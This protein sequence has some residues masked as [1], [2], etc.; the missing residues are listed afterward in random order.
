[1]TTER[2]TDESWAW[3]APR[4][5]DCAPLDGSSYPS[6]EFDGRQIPWPEWACRA[7]D[8]GVHID[9]RCSRIDLRLAQP[10]KKRL[11]YTWTCNF[12][13][14]LLAR[15]WLSR[16]EDL[17]DQHHTFKGDVVAG[18][19]PITNWATLHGR[20]APPLLSSDGRSKTCPIC[21]DVYA[22]L[23]GRVFFADPAAR[24]MPLIANRNGLAGIEIRLST[25]T[26]STRW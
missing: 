21:G 23:H 11:E 8:G 16:I 9:A 20:S 3:Y 5:P 24:S 25:P 6:A 14:R 4:T 15:T 1:M 22:T 7:P 10:P 18:G 12:G 26:N 17:V 13:V 2:R 19:Q